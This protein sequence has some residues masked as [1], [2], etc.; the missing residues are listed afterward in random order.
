M[1][2]NHF[3]KTI[4]VG[5]MGVLLISFV[6]IAVPASQAQSSS[7]WSSPV[8][9]SNA[10][11]ST[12]PSVVTDSSGV[13]H[14]I[15]L[16]EFDGYKYSKTTDGA[17][18]T[19]PKKVRLPFAP[20]DEAQPVFLAGQDNEMHVFWLDRTFTLHYSKATSEPDNPA[21]WSGT[22]RL[23]EGV[24][25]FHAAISQQDVLHV[26][27]VTVLAAQNN[28]IGVHYLNAK[29]NI[30]SRPQNLYTSQYFRSVES[31][32]ANVRVAV[33][34]VNEVE[35]VYLVW[36]DRSQKQILMAKSL[37]GGTLWEDRTLI[38]GSESTPGLET[39]F[40]INIGTVGNKVL[41]L[42]QSGIPGVQCSQYSQWSTDGGKQ[43]GPPEKV[44]DQFD[45]CPQ[46]SE[47]VV[48]NEDHSVVW[49]N[50]LNDVS[51]VAWDGAR[52]SA[53][54]SQYEATT[55]PNPVTLDSVFL[56]CQNFFF[57]KGQL[58]L[59][60][61]DMGASG[62][63]WFTSRSLGTLQDWFPPS[64]E[65]SSPVELASVDQEIA[66][67][68]SVA[69]H[70]NNIHALWVQTPIVNGVPGR[71]SIQYAGWNGE[72]WSSP[73]TVISGLE[74]GLLHISIKADSQNRLLLSWVDNKTGDIAFS[75]ANLDQASKASEWKKT[76]YLPSTSQA[77]SSPAI[78]ADDTGKILV[79]YAVSINEHRGIYFV[80]SDDGGV[81]WTQ[82]Y[83]VF[84][85]E[86]A[87]WDIVDQPNVT[88]TGDGRLHVLF[89]RYAWRAEQR[90]SL[91]LYYSQS[92][93]GGVT[94]SDPE[95]VSE[96][97]ILW[98]TVFGYGTSTL[99]RLWQENNQ[100][101]L[102]SLHQISQDGGITW[103][104]PIIVSSLDADSI[105]LM[106]QTVDRAGNLHLLELTGQEHPMISDQ[107]WN[108]AQWTPQELKELYVRDHGIPT[109][110]SGSV[111]SDGNLLLSVLVDFPPTTDQVPHG[112]LSV[113]KSLNLPKDIPASPSYVIAAQPVAAA[114]A[115]AS[116]VDPLSTQPSPLAGLSDQQ[117]S[118]EK[119]K[120]VVGLLLVGGV[121]LLII[122]IFRPIARK[123]N[124]VE[125]SQ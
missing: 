40:N 15:W 91:G 61:C 111:S 27:Y 72:S 54:Q 96:H 34:V 7:S 68:S 13:T 45:A 107:M 56:G 2:T 92:A 110:I 33:S 62:D 117:A 12:V 78:F 28:P 69:D 9:L 67:L 48:M 125:N 100:L 55:F 119:N 98:S 104:S 120:N 14:V 19:E 76:Q 84:D 95:M 52:W 83:Q 105:S 114:T 3:L 47:L 43:F 53:S 38:R 18:W 121:L 122:F 71:A 79:A 124:R 35:T 90:Q 63:I 51:L 108:G 39:P 97:P 22:R 21:R 80:T 20:Q 58:Q 87:A 32:N 30:W 59:V 82:P 60:G 94:W 36:D 103:S 11:S 75:W 74:P 49:L 6:L 42:W 31:E 101:T 16:D 50:T 29:K 17:T 4:L 102:L 5:L 10:G 37:D 66:A 109:S 8:N 65:W 70:Q 115:G 81:T 123:Q 118:L 73:V 24:V 46:A 26:G 106:T 89:K 57:H 88:L 93:D 64:T 99:H 1:R 85:A 86:L 41:L 113:G 44:L 112:I 116:D 23:A 77:N 25:D